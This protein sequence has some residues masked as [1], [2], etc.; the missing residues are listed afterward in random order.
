MRVDIAPIPEDP[1]S[2]EGG[3]DHHQVQGGQSWQ[4]EETRYPDGGGDDQGYAYEDG[5]QWGQ[6]PSPPSGGPPGPPPGPLP[7]PPPGPSL[8]PPLGP[9]PGPPGGPPGEWDQRAAHYPQQEWEAPT[10]SPPAPAGA[11]AWTTWG[12]N[13][14][15]A[16]GTS[17]TYRA[18]Q[19]YPAMAPPQAAPPRPRNDPGA[20]S[21]QNWDAEAAGHGYQPPPRHA[22]TPYQQPR[23]AFAGNGSYIPTGDRADISPHEQRVIFESILNS[24]GGAP[25]QPQQRSGRSSAQN[26]VHASKHKKSKREKRAQEQNPQNDWGGQQENPG[27]TQDN[28]GWG[29]QEGGWEQQQDT[30]LPGP[31]WD[32]SG[33]GDAGRGDP[34][35]EGYSDSGS[36]DDEAG[37]R[38][39]RQTVSG[40]F[41]P[42]P[43]GDSPYPMPSR[44]MAY[45]NGNAQDTLDAISPGLSRQRNTISD[46]AELQFLE[47]FGE[48]LKPVE[49]AFFG[50]DRKARDRIHWQFPHDKDERVRHALEWLEDH[51][52]GIGAFGLNKF[53][54]TRERGALFINASYDAPAGTGPAIDWLTYDDLVQ[55]RDHLLQE[56]VGFYDPG[57]QVIVFVLLPSKSGNSLAMW[58]RKVAVPNSVRLS[59]VRE[60]DLAKAALRKDYPVLVDEI[61]PLP[62]R[63]TSLQSQSVPPQLLPPL[64]PKKKK[65]GFFRKLFRIF[66]IVW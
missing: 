55:T 59:H 32:Q 8:G 33:G 5:D 53:L 9:P 40:A 63:P 64:K 25:K 18:A 1:T 12:R 14:Q 13:P 16:Y 56:S 31:A 51:G 36:W 7:G 57:S 44:T 4:G 22:G 30:G 17:R 42:G 34:D 46:F 39:F 21:W 10:T 28:S 47:S 15:G 35:G 54:Q 62:Y 2:Y 66:K 48:A 11:P 37:R 43:T 65:K 6:Y 45:A 41:V 49:N 50:R 20:T 29:R 23:V 24:R 38:N 26:S 19:Q 52:H 61:R 3:W 60:I 58:R 27:W